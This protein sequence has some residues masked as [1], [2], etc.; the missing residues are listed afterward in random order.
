LPQPFQAMP[1]FE[2]E[3]GRTDLGDV[4]DARVMS[5]M[6]TS[7]ERASATRKVEP[8]TNRPLGNSIWSPY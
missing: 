6:N 2:A 4:A 1:A 7:A 5:G 8:A 3:A